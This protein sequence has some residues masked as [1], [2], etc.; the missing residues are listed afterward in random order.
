MDEY[1]SLKI[2]DQ[3]DSSERPMMIVRAFWVAKTPGA[4]LRCGNSTRARRCEVDIFAC[5]GKSRNHTDR[6]R[7]LRIAASMP[8]TPLHRGGA[9]D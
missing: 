1:E 3:P 8:A 5:L 2:F 9:S 6:T 4:T 7:I